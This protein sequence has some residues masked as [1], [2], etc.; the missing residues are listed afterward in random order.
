MKEKSEEN[1]V[2]EGQPQEKEI[3][4]ME[5]VYKLWSQK[6]L[7]LMWCMWGAIAGLIIAF[8]IPKE[9]T[10]NVKL[11]P[12]TKGARTALTGGLGALAS[13][14]GI[15]AS[16][17]SGPDAVY[18]E[19]YPDI[20]SSIPF[21]TALFD[22][23]VTDQKGKTFT[24]REYL[25]EETSSPWWSGI[26][27]LPFK[28][29]G[30]LKGGASEDDKDHVTDN[31]KLTPKENGLVAT[32]NHRIKAHVDQKTDVIT[33]SVEMQDPLVSA[34]LVDTVMQRLQKY[35]TDY[36][37][38]KSR[39]DLIYALKLYGEAQQDYYD[40]QQRLADYI[41]RNQNLATRSAQVTRERLE[42]E[43]TLAFNL[44]NETALQVQ[45]A[46]SRVQET[47]PVF[48][49]ITP[50]TVPIRATSPRKGLILAGC[51]FLSFVAC[52]VWILFGSPIVNEYKRKTRNF[53]RETSEES[54]QEGTVN[55]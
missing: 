28:L 5:M 46:K 12:E 27:G 14:A 16:A 38:N 45:N 19:L 39:Q 54:E 21:A 11:A 55:L 7:I 37:T 25:E 10:A 35:V 34:M 43:A 13:M 17:N 22:V 4:L 41:D 47:T 18:P 3:D 8:S 52:A 20:V 42:N 36:R 49:Q 23:P 40:A 6:K 30:A 29:L 33:I 48:T 44:Y 51:T 31:F 26:M 24:V 9:F 32:L 50:A 53:K 15:S 1:K 2:K